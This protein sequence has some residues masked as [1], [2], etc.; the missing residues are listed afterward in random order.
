MGVIF[1]YYKGGSEPAPF[2]LTFSDF[3]LSFLLVQ[4]DKKDGRYL[5]Y[6]I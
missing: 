5:T 1:R 3:L 2:N 6:S 4:Y